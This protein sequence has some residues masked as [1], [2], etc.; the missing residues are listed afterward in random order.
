MKQ[1]QP[2]PEHLQ[3]IDWYAPHQAWLADLGFSHHEFPEGT[4]A[5]R[6]DL[7][8]A[9]LREADLMGAYLRGANLSGADLMG[10]DLTGANLSGARGIVSFGPCPGSRRIGY[11]VQHADCIVVQLGCWW[12][13]L[14]KTLDKLAADRTPAY[15]AIVQAAAM[16][17]EEGRNLEDVIEVI[18]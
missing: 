8:G 2:C 6:A 16:V 13:T 9:Y 3:S 15:V 4:V 18:E 12:D 17:L 1:K 10:A 11:A 7:R 14:D 5:A